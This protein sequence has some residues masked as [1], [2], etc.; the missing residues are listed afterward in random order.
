MPAGSMSWLLSDIKLF[1]SM[2]FIITD[3][4]MIIMLLQNEEEQSTG[5][6]ATIAIT[7]PSP[8]DIEPGLDRI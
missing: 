6:I 7:R 8:K 3:Y 2:K 5:D 1:G 4:L